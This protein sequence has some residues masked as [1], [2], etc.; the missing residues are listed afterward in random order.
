M[1][2]QPLAAVTGEPLAAVIDRCTA[3]AV[4]VGDLL[5]RVRDLASTLA[6]CWPDEHGRGWAERT[7]LVHRALVGEVAAVEDLAR[8]LQQ[9]ARALLDEPAEDPAPAVVPWTGGSARLGGTQA[10]RVGTDVGPEIAV[11]PDPDAAG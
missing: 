4:L 11:L 8:A 9:V 5:P 3:L 6:E 7:A 1:T 2:G 10:Q